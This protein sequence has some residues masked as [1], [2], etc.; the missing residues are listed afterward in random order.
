VKTTVYVEAGLFGRLD[1]P[2]KSG[3]AIAAVTPKVAS[4]PKNPRFTAR[5]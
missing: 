4:T 1:P 3:T 2:V 5:A